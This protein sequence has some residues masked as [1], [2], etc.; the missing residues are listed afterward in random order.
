MTRLDTRAYSQA[1]ADL[2]RAHPEE[3]AKNL[4]RRRLE[5]GLPAQVVVGLDLNDRLIARA[6]KRGESVAAIAE[7]LGAHPN[8]IR[9]RIRVLG[10]PKRKSGWN[11][12]AGRGWSGSEAVG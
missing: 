1:E 5:L 2:R 3:F 11:N 4:R 9:N 10:L 12:A 8:T 6:W 7:A